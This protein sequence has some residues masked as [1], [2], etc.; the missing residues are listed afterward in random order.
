MTVADL[1]YQEVVDSHPQLLAREIQLEEEAVAVAQ[2]A[3]VKR[4]ESR[5]LVDGS[6]SARA[7]LRGCVRLTADAIDQWVDAQSKITRKS[8]ALQHVLLLQS[9]Q[10][11]FITGRVM[12]DHALQEK[13]HYTSLCTRVA[14]QV[15]EVAEY[16]QFKEANIGLAT[17]VEKQ[18]AKTTSHKYSRAVLRATMRSAEFEGLKWTAQSLVCT[19]AVLVQSFC[20]ATGLFERVVQRGAKKRQAYINGTATL[21]LML[22]QADVMDSLL[23]PFHY[24]MVVPP[25]P[26]TSV[27]EGGYLNQRLHNLSL[28][29]ARASEA[30]KLDAT[31][32]SDVMD[33]VNAIQATPWKIN[34]QVLEVLS[35]M[36]TSGGGA[37]VA[38]SQQPELP[39]TPWPEM[40]KEEW[41]AWKQC[42]ANLVQLEEWSAG[43]KHVY[44][45]R[46]KWA[47]KRLVQQQQIKVGERFKDEDAI[48]FPHTLDFRSRIYPAAGLGTVNPQ[49]NDA[50]KSLLKFA[51]GLPLG[52]TGARWLAIHAANLYGND[53]V[54]LADREMWTLLASDWIVKC[55]EQ[56]LVNTQ[57]QDA[58]KPFCFLAVCFE[59]AGYMKQG[60]SFVSHL[61]I[62][63]DGSASGLQH[64][65]AMLLDE[66]TARAVNVV[67]TGD[68]PADVYTV[69]LDS[70]KQAVA[71]SCDDLA[72]E[73]STRLRRDIVKQPVM[74]KPYGVT[75]RGVVGQISKW[76]GKLTDKGDIE[77]FECQAFDAAVWLAPKV[78]QAIGEELAA[79][80]IAMNWLK[81]VARVTSNAG[82][83]LH[84][85]TAIGF[86][87]F[88][89]YRSLE[90]TEV[91]I[92][93]GG[94]RQVLSLETQG[95]NLHAGRQI[96]SVAPNF[97][98]SQDACH[99]M[100]TVNNCVDN[101]IKDFAMI[102]DSFGTHAC[103]TGMLNE[104]LR[105]CFIA[106]YSGNMLDDLW[107]QVRQQVSADTFALIEPPPNQ[108]TLEIEAV[109][110]SL[111][112]F[113]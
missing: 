81:H 97:V 71:S 67:Q 85:E 37:G 45:E 80:D 42:P 52:E 18:I 65:A 24:P 5:G 9:D 7:S 56:P 46:T 28:V 17:K 112:F 107:H 98:H 99:L 6:S 23:M 40:Q 60:D 29:K 31:D 61:P 103:N 49:G 69:V 79:A 22:A 26:W 55:A 59:W 105:E 106:M 104:V 57:W 35:H 44:H 11:A 111:Y 32:L 25:V 12:L 38:A 47:S 92:T 2:D 36:N 94:K 15:M 88:Q 48:Y 41:T 54:S 51:R 86:T 89:N 102:H 16:A 82:L 77:P 3:C 73:W 90:T 62:A 96:S 63:M 50:G 87:V 101:G 100:I 78:Q 108:S 66:P 84:W 19:G 21:D 83:A 91:R 110:D 4:V 58:D 64:Y 34:T 95:S 20:D 39:I 14:R 68:T 70:V 53:K 10:L 75:S 72:T 74:T 30:A 33:S 109:R 43:A 76:T 27:S 13:V 113:A 93:W 8:A 1:T